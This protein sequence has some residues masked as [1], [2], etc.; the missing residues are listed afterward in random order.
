MDTGRLHAHNRLSDAY[1]YKG[2]DD[3]AFESFVNARTISGALPDEIDLWKTIYAR[4]GWKGILERQLEY[5][6]AAERNGKPNYNRLANLSSELGQIDEAFAYLEKSF[7]QRGVGLV[8]LNTH[9]RYDP[10]RGDPRF[11]DLV[12]RVGLKK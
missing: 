6:K 2:D 8:Y 5:A 10:L 11:D 12:R 1:R 3:R 4:S 7:V 9:P